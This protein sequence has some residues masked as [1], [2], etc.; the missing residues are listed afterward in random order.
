MNNLYCTCY[1]EI[2]ENPGKREC[3]P[4]FIYVG[5]CIS[6]LGKTKR[7]CVLVTS[8]KHIRIAR[9]FCSVTRTSTISK[10]NVQQWNYLHYVHLI[11]VPTCSLILG[12][13]Y[14]LCDWISEG[15]TKTSISKS[16]IT[17]ANTTFCEIGCL[18]RLYC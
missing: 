8:K 18:V 11:T 9:V 12:V 7:I 14:Y 17:A 3:K 13:K 6:N 2:I 15:K 10:I 4:T 1:I 16:F 5:S